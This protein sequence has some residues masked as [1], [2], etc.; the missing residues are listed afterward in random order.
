MLKSFIATM[1]VGLAILSAHSRECPDR[2]D[3]QR[4]HPHVPDG[5]FDR[6]DHR[7]SSKN[8]LPVCSQRPVSA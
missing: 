5:A 7:I 4:R 3:D 8:G 2:A 1:V 6:S